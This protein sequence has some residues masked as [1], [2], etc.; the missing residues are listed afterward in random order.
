MPILG[1]PPV[2]EVD[3]TTYPVGRSFGVTR[4]TVGDVVWGQVDEHGVE[5][6]LIDFPGWDDTPDVVGEASQRIG[7][8]G[9]LLGPQ[10]YAG[11]TLTLEGRI[12]ARSMAD[13]QAALSRM[14]RS[15]PVNSL[16]LV[17]VSDPPEM[18][19]RARINGQIRVARTGV[20]A[21]TVQIPLLAPDP[22]RY[23]L[24]PDPITITLPTYSDGLNLPQ[25]LPFTLIP[26]E[27]NGSGVV[28]N[29][30]DAWSPWRATITGPI[31]TPT[32]TVPSLGAS[33]SVAITV[34]AGQT[35]AI[36]S[37]DKIVTLDGANRSGLVR[38]ASSWFRLPPESSTEIRLSASSVDPAV[39]PVL[40][41]YPLPACI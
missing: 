3:G 14:R 33:F 18:Y 34:E 10:T 23:L 6:H 17:R 38:R 36:D 13:R 28:V 4:V 22:L 9:L 5:W 15:V 24:N 31:G 37:R 11:R 8:H 29:T 20:N 21:A 25:V 30:G 16:A 32:I 26:R 12:V 39:A 41:F 1:S 19:V 2:V 35:L 27:Q 40:T 7:E